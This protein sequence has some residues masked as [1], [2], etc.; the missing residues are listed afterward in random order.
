MSYIYERQDSNSHIGK[1]Y[2]F[3]IS[4][5]LYVSIFHFKYIYT[6]I[7][8]Y[9]SYIFFLL[10]CNNNNNMSN[11]S[12]YHFIMRVLLAFNVFS[13]ILLAYSTT[14]II[15]SAE[16]LEMNLFANS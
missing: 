7:L 11:N 8:I 12:I 10:I 16:T 9:I 4:S 3:R 2:I 14:L 1:V 13:S 5:K 6:D 15:S